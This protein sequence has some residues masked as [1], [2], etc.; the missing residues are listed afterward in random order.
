MVGFRHGSAV[1]LSVALLL[2]VLLHLAAMVSGGSE[3]C[4]RVG[5]L[6]LGPF[7]LIASPIRSSDFKPDS[8]TALGKPLKATAAGNR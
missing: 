7:A 6:S 5:T 2:G 8:K 4:E 1:I 3:V